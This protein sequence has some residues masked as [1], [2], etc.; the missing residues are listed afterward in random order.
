MC[1]VSRERG[2]LCMFPFAELTPRLL[3][4]PA[5][6]APLLRTRRRHELH[7]QSRGASLAQ[8][9]ERLQ[10]HGGAHLSSEFAES[11]VLTR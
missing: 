9:R 3:I 8:L 5:G 2:C 4:V 11:V 7:V 10:N 1:R 6:M